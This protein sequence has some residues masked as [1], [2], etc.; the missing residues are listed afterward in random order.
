[1]HSRATK[2]LLG[3]IAVAVF[4]YLGCAASGSEDD[5]SS[6]G[7]QSGGAPGAGGAGGAGGVGGGASGGEGGTLLP[8][9]GAGT[10]GDMGCAQFTVEG[11]QAPAAMLMA[12]DMT[13][14]MTGG[15]WGAA[16]LATVAA[17]DKDVFDSM[18]LGLV[19][20]PTAFSNPPQC[21][22]DSIA[23]QLGI[24]IDYSTCLLLVSP[25]VSCGVSA[26]PQVP[27][28]LAGTDKSNASSGVRKNIYDYLV[29]NTPISSQDDG[30]PIY[31]ALLAG[32]NAL[33]FVSNVD[34]RMLVLVT[35]GGF[36]CTSLA[37]PA[38]SAFVDANGCLDW[39]HPDSVNQLISDHFND[40]TTP[41]N[42]FIVGVPGSD[43]NG[44]TVGAFDTPPYSMK[45]ALST[46]AVSGSPNTVD[47]AC[48][49]GLSF[50][51]GGSDPAAPCHF[52]MSNGQTFDANALAD[53]IAEIRGKALGCVY[54][55][56]D[57]PPGE[58]INPD[59][60]NVEITVDGS[61]EQIPRR[62]DPSDECL[63]SGCW[64]YDAN[65]DIVIIGKSCD[66]LNSANQ[67]KVE[68]VVGCMTVLK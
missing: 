56:P 68:I 21:I 54:P 16:Q 7:N 34:E 13:A 1:M 25:G 33:K 53:T 42:T 65:G 48:D 9:G 23:S 8:T 37:N 26:L 28:Q 57:P 47:A 59:E 31:E 64:D 63:T 40:P 27:L 22:C 2:L 55:L 43:T 49:S 45:L 35:D 67:A 4:S 30:S 36:S 58:T 3:V 20:F 51:Q 18:S 17:I 46:Y 62:S 44:E 38:R 14:S 52:D 10:G 61:T 24:A 41:I 5:D 60:V 19:T 32:Y 15:K 39:E 50:T 12:L 11:E 6:S 29:A 66:D